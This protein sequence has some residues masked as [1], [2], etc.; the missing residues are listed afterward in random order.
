LVTDGNS[1]QREP[2]LNDLVGLDHYE[3]TDA[4]G[5]A[6]NTPRTLGGRKT[7][8]VT[9]TY[10]YL[11]PSLLKNWAAAVALAERA[12]QN[13][14]CSFFF[15][16]SGSGIA[17]AQ[18]LQDVADSTNN[19]QYLFL[20]YSTYPNNYAAEAFWQGLMYLQPDGNYNYNNEERPP[21]S[22][23]FTRPTGTYKP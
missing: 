18:A 9:P 8:P 4:T 15:N 12:L 1:R 16:T 19:S 22:W 14:L 6:R 5:M 13:P 7:T 17:S 23:R 20:G 11:S 21:A 10:R 3:F 2:R